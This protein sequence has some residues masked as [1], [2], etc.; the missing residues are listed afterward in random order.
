MRGPKK[1]WVVQVLIIVCLKANPYA[2]IGANRKML[3]GASTRKKHKRVKEEY[4][5]IS[6]EFYRLHTF[7]TLIADVTF[8]NGIPFLVNFSRN[9]IWITCKYVSTCTA[10]KL[11]KSLMKILKL[12]ARGGFVT[13]LVLMYM[14]PEKV[15]EKFSLL[16]PNTTSA[17][18]YAADIEAIW[19]T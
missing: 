14:E 11:A 5:K 10:G 3:R 8:M 18:E 16:E 9:I 7:V 12:Y 19:F 1:L 6:K 13:S 17:R 15:K 4:I 2:I